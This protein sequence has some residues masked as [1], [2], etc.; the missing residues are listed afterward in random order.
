[1][2]LAGRNVV[3]IDDLSNEEIETV[4]RL[5]DDIA[6][7]PRRFWG[8]ATAK[9]LATLFHEPS[10]R[11]RLSFESAMQRLGGGVISQWDIN[12]SSAAKGETLAD[13]VR[14]L[15]KYADAIVLRHPWEGASHLAARYAGV[16][17]VNAGDGGHEHPTQTLCDLY[18][19]KKRHKT[20][21]GLTVALCGDLRSGRTIHSLAFALVRF[22]AGVFFVPGDGKDVPQHVLRRLEREYDTPV[23]RVPMG[24]LAALFGGTPLAPDAA[25][26]V[27]AI[28]M[29]PTAPNQ[30]ALLQEPGTR[31]EISRPDTH[32][33]ALYI[34]RFQKERDTDVGAAHGVGRYPV[35][36][37]DL[38]KL[39]EFRNVSILHPLP[40]VD[41]LSVEI[42]KDPRS[43]YFEQAGYGIPVRMALLH[44]LLGLDEPGPAAAWAP[45]ERAHRGPTYARP[46]GPRCQNERCAT[47]H[48]PNN[49]A[50][51]FEVIQHPDPEPLLR[52][53]YCDQEMAPPLYGRIKDKLYYPIA[54]LRQNRARLGNVAFF[55]SPSDAI[56]SGYRPG[57]ARRPRPKP[58]NPAQPPKAAIKA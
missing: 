52:C 7:C 6:E 18:T 47:R 56:D 22:G 8:R 28:Y 55:L 21:Q 3:S 51:S 37:R 36:T 33:L 57:G 5:A 58:R 4:F 43:A 20:L 10:T 17:V 40:R 12:A 16:P 35:V 42:D 26:E 23:R 19:L 31:V 2:S 32:S 30:P 34:T 48:E 24:R 29:T 1:M 13:T 41:E 45:Y 9:V 27:D 38:L 46:E 53:L 44:L 14:V 11:T 49:A 50:P 39:R 15:G 25:P 54:S